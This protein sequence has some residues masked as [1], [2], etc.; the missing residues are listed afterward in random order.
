MNVKKVGNVILAVKDLNKS[1]EFSSLGV[2]AALS[3]DNLSF[4]FGVFTKPI[5]M[6]PSVSVSISFNIFSLILSSL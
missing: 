1:V 3:A 6:F 2:S 5:G 4:S